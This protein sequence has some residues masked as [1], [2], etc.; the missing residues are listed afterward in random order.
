MSEVDRQFKN[1]ISK[2]ESF[3]NVTFLPDVKN[4]ATAVDKEG[5]LFKLIKGN[6]QDI[7]SD[8]IV[9]SFH[10]GINTVEAIE[11]YMRIRNLYDELR[12]S[13]CYFVDDD[14]NVF[15]GEDA[16][17]IK[18][19]KDEQIILADYSGTKEDARDLSGKKIVGKSR[20]KKTKPKFYSS[21]I[22]ALKDFYAEKIPGDEEV[23]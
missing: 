5:E 16:E 7:R 1:L 14:G 11:W 6:F 22:E 4:V 9:L 2:L 15:F 23:Q 18:M 10:L 8:S 13:S 12:L 17:L 20:D 19:Y 21:R 3:Y